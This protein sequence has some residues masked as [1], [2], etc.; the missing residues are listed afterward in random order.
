MQ[1]REHSYSYLF[2]S[3][4]PV[5]VLIV[6]SI[7]M[8]Y[9]FY[10]SGAVP[11]GDDFH[12]HMERAEN[13]YQQLVSQTGF[14]YANF[15][16]FHQ[17][18]YPL[19][20]F[21]P[22]ITF[23]PLALI[24]FI[25]E[26]SPITSYYVFLCFLQIATLLIC[27]FTGRKMWDSRLTAFT[28]AILYGFSSY[29][30]FDVFSRAAVGEMIALTFFPLAIY[31]MYAIIQGNR[32]GWLPLAFGMT[33]LIY[34]HLLSVVLVAIILL[35]LFLCYLPQFLEDRRKLFQ[36]IYAMM[37]TL[38]LSAITLFPL[39]E[40]MKETKLT[41]GFKPIL[42]EYKIPFSENLI[43]SFT[44]QVNADDWNVG[45]F[46]MLAMV[47]GLVFWRKISKF[48]RIMLMIAV[49]LFLT[50]GLMDW[51]VVQ[52]TPIAAIQFP[53]RLHGQ[54]T[55]CALLVAGELVQIGIQKVNSVSSD[56]KKK[57]LHILEGILL[58]GILLLALWAPNHLRQ[59]LTERADT[60]DNPDKHITYTNKNY[61]EYIGQRPIEDYLTDAARENIESILNHTAFT[62]TENY[63]EK[64]VKDQL[65]MSFTMPQEG[66][67][68][69]Y[70]PYYKGFKI[71]EQGKNIPIIVS[72][73][74]TI[75]ADLTK[76]DHQL[77]VYYQM[78]IIQKISW[79]LSISS[80][81]ALLLL[82][83]YGRVKKQ[84]KK[85]GC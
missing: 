60:T 35:I 68:T 59:S 63:Q 78:T 52:H 41:T 64:V 34:S 21:Y 71:K 62:Q 79:V 1:K 56:Q 49:V 30:L 77:V 18:G 44:N 40:Q 13:W 80:W 58:T 24:R 46:V 17:V 15:Y 32:R 57:R 50:E 61:A 16:T 9:P 81:L 39:L 2:C 55:V 20:L 11:L 84:R 19:D 36:L 51:D 28:F 54:I 75:Q 27:Y 85:G 48:S 29:R 73:E 6:L 8:I 83:V 5:L 10:H 69:T 14:N 12:F 74:G 70:V 76:G 37:A 3:L 23:Y 45:L 42:E 31:G 26:F 66:Q 47:L 25:L 72:N 33:L 43:T 22:F 4:F 38:A 53:W 82:L 7:M 65:Q 67:F